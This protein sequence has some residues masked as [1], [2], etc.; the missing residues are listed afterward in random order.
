MPFG[1]GI[2]ELVIIVAVLGTISAVVA[3]TFRHSLRRSAREEQL[4]AS[5]RDLEDQLEEKRLHEQ[6]RRPD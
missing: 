2:M 4:E 6:L 1:L 5:V 3:R